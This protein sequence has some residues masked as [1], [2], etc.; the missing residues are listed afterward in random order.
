MAKL[1]VLHVKVN[2]KP[3]VKTIEHNIE[4]M[5]KLVG[6]WIES[7]RISEDIL[8]IVNEEGM[9]H[10]LPIN[11]ISFVREGAGIVP[12]H[13]IHGDVFF[14]SM[15]GEDFASLDKIQIQTIKQMFSFNRQALLIR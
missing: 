9:V 13:E 8:M 12:V 2:E 3:K 6:G 11:F 14:V 5:H 4:E 15:I 1:T 10:D 7:V